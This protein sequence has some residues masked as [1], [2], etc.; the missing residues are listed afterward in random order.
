MAK[1]NVEKQKPVSVERREMAANT[2]N[3]DILNIDNRRS[4][5]FGGYLHVM[6]Y[7]ASVKDLWYEVEEILTLPKPEQLKIKSRPG[8]FSEAFNSLYQE[9]QSPSLAPVRPSLNSYSGSV[10]KHLSVQNE[11]MRVSSESVLKVFDEIH[12]KTFSQIEPEIKIPSAEEKQRKEDWEAE[13]KFREGARYLLKSDNLV[14]ASWTNAQKSLKPSLLDEDTLG[15]FEEWMDFHPPGLQY[16]LIG[17]TNHGNKNIQNWVKDGQYI[18]HLA[19][20]GFKHIVL[21]RP[22]YLLPILEQINNGDES[23]LSHPEIITWDL[24]EI[25][26]QAMR[27]GIK[28]HSFDEQVTKIRSSGMTNRHK[29]DETLYEEITKATGA[30]KTAIIY[31]A[32]HFAYKR[33]LSDLLGLEKCR[34]INIH[35]NLEH[36]MKPLRINS[37]EPAPYVYVVEE[38][39]V[40]ASDGKYVRAIKPVRDRILMKMVVP[41]LQEHEQKLFD[42][43]LL[44]AKAENP[45][46][47]ADIKSDEMVNRAV[48]RHAFQALGMSH[49]TAS[50]LTNAINVIEEAD[51]RRRGGN[52]G[53]SMP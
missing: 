2:R 28:V 25:C 27:H 42:K 7:V 15:T 52:S 31:G 16:L 48:H 24:Q 1:T 46:K 43:E 20:K 21:E 17:D 5:D 19:R 11:F 22:A 53:L 39:Q 6:P 3:G 44:A 51:N 23:A 9:F 36:Y 29:Y 10:G 41:N 13:R 32:G 26:T 4:D 8:S 33:S 12:D 18:E 50:A 34:H 47:Y 14:D 37:I 49:M 38:A 30:D 40:I 45:E 35:S